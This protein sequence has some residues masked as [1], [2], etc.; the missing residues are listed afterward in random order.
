MKKFGIA[1]LL[2]IFLALPFLFYGCKNNGDIRTTYNMDLNFDEENYLL[3]GSEEV[4]YYNNSENAFEYLYFHLY[5]NAYRIDNKNKIVA[6]NYLTK[7]YPNGESDGCIDIEYVKCAN[8]EL[9][10]EIEGEN[11]NILKVVLPNDLYPDEKIILNIGFTVQ[12]ANTYHR[13]GYGQNTI[14]FGNFYPIAC[15]YE[16]G[17]GFRKDLYTSNGD[18]FYSECSNYNVNITF[19][20]EYQIATSG[21][22]I[23]NKNDENL[24]KIS[25]KCEKM[26]DF[27]FILSKNFKIEKEIYQKIKINYF[28]YQEDDNTNECFKTCVDAVKTFSELFGEYPYGELSVAKSNFFYGGMEYPGLVLISDELKTQSEINY[29]IVHEIAHQWWYGVVGSDQINHAWQD[30]GLAEFSTLLFFKHNLEYGEDY[31]KLIESATQSYQLFEK[32]YKNVNG[33]VDTSMDRSLSQFATEPEYTQ[34]TYTKGVLMF[35]AVM[36]SVGEKKLLKGFKKYYKD[37]SFLIATPENLIDCMNRGSGYNLESFI[38]S[39]LDGK[40]VI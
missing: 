6:D 32:V 25:I 12:L 20:F 37:F 17:K 38:R 11:C 5:P 7:A 21:E 4:E 14:N 24:K 40:V 8:I 22:I 16:N 3:S 28:G 15:V 27:S 26:R 9:E 13:L 34:N 33:Q 35:D 23:S 10:T 19:P 1:I 39:W 36:Q 30:E 31:S 29:V 2:F 18:P